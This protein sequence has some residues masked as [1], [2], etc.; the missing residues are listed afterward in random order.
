VAALNTIHKSGTP[1]LRPGHTSTG[2]D[3][4]SGSDSEFRVAVVA[5]T[6]AGTIAALRT[7][8]TLAAGLCAK[9]QL[10]AVEEVPFRLSLDTPQQSADFMQGRLQT[11]LYAS[12]I[13]ADEVAIDVWFCRDRDE[14]LRWILPAR[15]LVVIG[16]KGL[17]WCWREREL[18]NVLMNLGHHVIFA[19]LSYGPGLRAWWRG[20]FTS[21]PRP[22]RNPIHSATHRNPK[23][24]A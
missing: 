22:S 6:T 14:G 13:R 1:A 16:G 5:T 4:D 24:A 20:L 21:L 7:A 19:E 10:V 17:R 8:G 15:S 2:Y 18:Q 11:L 23:K 3:L 12:G 9:I